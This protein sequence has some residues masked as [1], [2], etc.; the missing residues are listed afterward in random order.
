MTLY[1]YQIRNLPH[2][3]PT[4]FMD[5]YTPVEIYQ[6]H[7]RDVMEEYQAKQ[8]IPTVKLISEIRVK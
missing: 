8:N 6:A 3:Y 1:E 5:G 2:Y 4:M 7:Q